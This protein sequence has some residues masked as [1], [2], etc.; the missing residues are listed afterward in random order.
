MFYLQK[1]KI[2]NVYRFVSRL[3]DQKFLNTKE[4][5][6]SFL[7]VSLLMLTSRAICAAYR[8]TERDLCSS[9]AAS[10]TKFHSLALKT[11]G[12]WLHSESGT[13]GSAG[14]RLEVLRGAALPASALQSVVSSPP[15]LGMHPS[16]G[17]RPLPVCL[18]LCLVFLYEDTHRG[19]GTHP[20]QHDLI[21]TNLQ[22][23]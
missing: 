17:S 23:P 7:S 20:R 6:A 14:M 16:V 21:I 12:I 13:Q 8:G 3:G 9:A 18:C 5:T 22:E 4:D 19:L 1:K 11:P 2:E 10:A 15:W